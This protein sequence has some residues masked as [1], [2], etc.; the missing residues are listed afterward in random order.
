MTQKSEK[1]DIFRKANDA[2]VKLETMIHSARK[3]PD[4]LFHYTPNTGAVEGILAK[5]QLWLSPYDDMNDPS[6]I[7]HGL[8]LAENEVKVLLPTVP[9]HKLPDYTLFLNDLKKRDVLGTDKIRFYF[10]CFTEA[11][12]DDISQWRAY[13]N[14]GFGYCIEFESKNA[15]AGGGKQDLLQPLKP[16]LGIHPIIYDDAAKTTMI[17]SFLTIYAPVI[18]SGQQQGR[19]LALA[20]LVQLCTFFK[21][22]SYRAEQEWRHIQLS[23]QGKFFNQGLSTTI[24]QLGDHYREKLVT[25]LPAQRNPLDAVAA[26]TCGPKQNRARFLAVKRRIDD[27]LASVSHTFPTAPIHNISAFHSRIP[28][29]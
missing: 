21:H 19:E 17:K 11:G 5:N 12:N 18:E 6:E 1:N 23:Y 26:I 20:F 2:W 10:S 25:D 7:I 9:Q 15:F 22:P 14:G 8:E 4:R 3:I 16:L 27:A 28:M 24:F 29:V 13:A